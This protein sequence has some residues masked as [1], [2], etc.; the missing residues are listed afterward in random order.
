MHVCYSK[1]RRLSVTAAIPRTRNELVLRNDM[2][3][4]RRGKQT[5]RRLFLASIGNTKRCSNRLSGRFFQLLYTHSQTI[6]FFI[7]T[8]PGWLKIC[9]FPPLIRAMTTHGRHR[10]RS[11]GNQCFSAPF[12][13]NMTTIQTTLSKSC[14]SDEIRCPEKL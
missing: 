3:V 6:M 8:V 9:V 14:L 5:P 7:C 2:S 4:S 1:Y 13:I 12:A 11:V 10:L